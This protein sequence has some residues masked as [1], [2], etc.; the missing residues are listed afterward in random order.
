[1]EV[2]I[3]FRS[4]TGATCEASVS[5]AASFSQAFAAASGNGF[6]NVKHDMENVALYYNVCFSCCMDWHGRV[7]P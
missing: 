1:M 2:K 6:S 4:I 3:E 7:V 5:R